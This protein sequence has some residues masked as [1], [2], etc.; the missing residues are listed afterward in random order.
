MR[1]LSFQRNELVVSH[2]AVACPHCHGQNVQLL[3]VIHAAGT[4]RIKT[5]HQVQSGVGPS[6]TV[7]T[8]GKHQ[9]DLAASVSPP[10]GK[11]LLGPVV[12][13]IVGSIILYDGLKLMNTWWGVDWTRFFIGVAFIAIGV[14]GFVRHW[15]FNVAQ[16]DKLEVWRRSWLCHACGTRFEPS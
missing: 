11:R 12:L 4:S 6:V 15:R 13:T 10:P 3:S 9:T 7:E 1:T 16:Y 8:T 14:I 5:T 2:N